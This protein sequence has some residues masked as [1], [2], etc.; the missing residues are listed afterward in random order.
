MRR[1]WLLAAVLLSSR[2]ARSDGKGATTTTVAVDHDGGVQHDDHV[3][4]HRADDHPAGDHV[5]STLATTSST[6]S[7]AVEHR[8][9]HDSSNVAQPSVTRPVTSGPIAATSRRSDKQSPTTGMPTSDAS[10]RRRRAIRRLHVAPRFDCCAERD[11]VRFGAQHCSMAWL[12]AVRDHP[13]GF[14]LYTSSRSDFG[15]AH[16]RGRDRVRLSTRWSSS[17]RQDP[18]ASPTVV[19][20][21]AV[22]RFGIM[23]TCHLENGA[24]ASRRGHERTR[25]TRAGDQCAQLIGS[26]LPSSRSSAAGAWSRR[27]VGTAPQADDD[28]VG[29]CDVTTRG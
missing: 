24:L 16:A 8:R 28:D 23:H 3:H 25:R 6:S 22:E 17:V 14:G 7:S 2:A 27:L 4:H 10:K 9:R 19:D 13:T 5:T 21:S 1:S 20:D 15:E 18:T 12:P 11:R 29:A 26:R